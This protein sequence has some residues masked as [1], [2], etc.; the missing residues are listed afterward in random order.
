MPTLVR[1]VQSPRPPG[2]LPVAQ[3]AHHADLYACAHPPVP[4]FF[5]PPR[6]IA[7]NKG[8]DRLQ[9]VIFAVRGFAAF[10]RREY[11]PRLVFS[12]LRLCG[13]GLVCQT[14]QICEMPGC[15]AHTSRAHLHAPFP[16]RLS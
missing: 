11:L 10:R 1:P 6:P 9:M 7:L 12:S 13:Q 16:V 3:L 15:P 5:S 8:R 2:Q 14:R 4:A